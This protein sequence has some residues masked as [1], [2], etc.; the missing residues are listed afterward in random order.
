MLEAQLSALVEGRLKALKE[1]D[2]L[3]NLAR[4]HDTTAGG[5]RRGKRRR[6]ANLR[7]QLAWPLKQDHARRLLDM[8]EVYKSTINLLLSNHGKSHLLEFDMRGLIYYA[9]LSCS[10]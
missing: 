8:L 5:D 9:A 7:V 1:L 4:F 10:T 2:A 3:I 6:L